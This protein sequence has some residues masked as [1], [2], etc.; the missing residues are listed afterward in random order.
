MI[1]TVLFVSL[2]VFLV[3]NVPVGIA[4]GLSS[5]TSVLLNPRLSDS[6]IVQQ[7]ISGSDSFPIMAIPLFILAGELMAAGGVSKRIL[8]VCSAF[9]GRITGRTCHCNRCCL[10]VLCSF[11]R[12]RPGNPLQQSEPWLFLLCW[13]RDTVRAFLWRVWHVR[14]VSVLLSRRVSRWLSTVYPPVHPFQLCSWPASHLVS[15]SVLSF[16]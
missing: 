5:W 11:I 6:F 3:L 4:I 8:N 13:R 14:A 7:L 16:V 2:I 15:S 10:Y 9:F 12:F 1:T